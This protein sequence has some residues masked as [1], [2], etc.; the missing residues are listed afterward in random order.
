MFFGLVSEGYASTS[1]IHNLESRT[2]DELL[3]LVTG[4]IAKIYKYL[5]LRILNGLEYHSLARVL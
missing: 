2:S 4:R 5:S 1:L 3:H